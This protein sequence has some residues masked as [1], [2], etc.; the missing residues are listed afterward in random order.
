M[1]KWMA[2]AGA[3]AALDYWADA[4]YY[5]ACSAQPT[6]YAELSSTYK[7]ANTTPSFDAKSDGTTSGRKIGVQA[8]TGVSVGGSGTVTHVG[9]GK[10][11]GT[12]LKYVTTTASQAVSSGGTVDIGAWAIEVRD[13]S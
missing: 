10:A 7:L 4:D 2:D 3:D 13:P 8:K 11:S 1:A 12:L 9:L 5:A 6:S